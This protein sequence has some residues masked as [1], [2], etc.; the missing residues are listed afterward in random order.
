MIRAMHDEPA[1]ADIF[2]KFL[3]GRSMRTQANL[4]DQLFNS[5]EKRLV[6]ILLLMAEF[7]RTGGT[8]DLY[9]ISRCAV[10]RHSVREFGRPEPKIRTF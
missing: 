4:V 2:L 3:L 7:G 5:S 8:E 1:V 6:R 9:S 10:S